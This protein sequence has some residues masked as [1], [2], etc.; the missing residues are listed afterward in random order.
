MV[1][2]PPHVLQDRVHYG[3]AKNALTLPPG[4]H[5]YPFSFKVSATISNHGLNVIPL[6]K[7]ASVQ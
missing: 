1:F 6:T 7:T 4:T 2:P 3:V 5:E